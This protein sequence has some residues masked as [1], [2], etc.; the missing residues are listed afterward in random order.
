M[1]GIPLILS[2]L[3]GAA[4]PERPQALVFDGVTVIDVERGQALPGMT[5]IVEG[6]RI[7]QVGRQPALRIPPGARVVDGAG[8]FLIPG[9]WDMHVH[10]AF[11]DWFPGARD[12]AL[13]LFVANGVTGVRDM[14]GDLEV[15]I[16]WRRAI[17][18][19]SLVGPR[20]VISGPM[21]DG[22][23]PRFPSSVAIAT[24]EDGRR[25]VRDLKARGVDF[26]KL[27]SLIPRDA[28]FAIAEEARKAGIP[29]AGHVPD[30]V[31]AGEMSAAGQKSFEHLIGVFE[32]SSSGEDDF[33]KGGMKS[34]GRFLAGFDE[35]RLLALAASLARNHTWQCPTLAW[36]QGGNLIEERDLEHDPLARYAPAS[37]RSGTW[38]RFRDQVMGEFN[39]DDLAT[40]KRFLAKELEVVA[41]L[42]RAGVPFLAGTDTVAGIYIFPGFSL[43]DELGLLVRAGFTPIEALRTATQRPAEYLS[44]SDRLGSVEKGKRADL[45]LLDKNPLDDIAHTRTIRAVVANG[46]YFSREDLDALLAA[47]EERAGD[48]R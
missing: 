7:A 10:T 2:V 46:R 32:A 48:K 27:Q 38:K 39:V 12:I 4:A 5:V 33:V 43:H 15:L 18:Q 24:P 17:A 37:W 34:P 44:M 29:F 19:G 41:A 22:P 1:R 3:L 40:R 20:M 36:E 16:E 42:H 21:L 28:V 25:A 11:G 6:E 47:V 13:P 45:V 30:A 26:I 8:R 9:L 23:K 31:R 14:G 35:A